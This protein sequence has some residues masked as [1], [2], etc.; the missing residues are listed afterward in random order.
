MTDNCPP[1]LGGRKPPRGLDGW[2]QRAPSP[3]FAA[4]QT[5]PV[6]VSS[7]DSDPVSQGVPVPR[8]PSAAWREDVDGTAVLVRA[9]LAAGRS[10]AKLVDELSVPPWF[11]R[12]FGE[13]MA[14]RRR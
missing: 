5:Q 13:A 7:G 10:V 4:L 6:A 12:I 2:L 9:G 1:W 11:V 8:A 14:T 3:R